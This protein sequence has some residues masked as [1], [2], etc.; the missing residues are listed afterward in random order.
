VTYHAAY[1]PVRSVR[2]ERYRYVRRFDAT[3]PYRGRVGPNTDPGAARAHLA[4]RGYFAEQPP[5]EALYDLSADP[6]ERANLAGDPAHEAVRADLESRL[7]A[8]MERTGDPLLAGPVSKP[9]GARAHR[10]DA[11]SHSEQA[12][13]PADAR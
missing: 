3:E 12:F 1:E 13:E 5:D 4:E 10:R 9:S 11:D 6:G 8:W 7:R 2:T